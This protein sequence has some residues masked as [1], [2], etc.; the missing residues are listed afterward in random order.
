MSNRTTPLALNPSGT[1][2]SWKVAQVVNSLRRGKSANVQ[3]VTLRA[4]QTTTVVNDPLV[5][6]ESLIVLTPLTSSARTALNS[7]HYTPIAGSFTITHP[8]NAATD[9]NVRYAVLG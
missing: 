9:Q 1:D 8:S 7:A 5:S 3:D 6:P 4:S 2:P